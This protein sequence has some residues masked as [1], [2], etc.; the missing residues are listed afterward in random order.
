MP[1][2]NKPGVACVMDSLESIQYHKDTSYFF[3]LAAY[4]L[5]CDIF[6]ID[7][8]D[9]FLRYNRAWAV[10]SQLALTKQKHL[11]IEQRRELPLDE[12]RVILIRKDPPFDRR[13]FYTTLLLDLLPASTRV[14]NQ[15]SA[16]RDW[17]EKLAALHFADCTPP[18]LVSRDLKAI[19]LFMREQQQS[20]AAERFVLKPLDG[21]GG[22]GIKFVSGVEEL[23]TLVAATHNFSRYIVVQNYIDNSG[24]VRVIL[25]N[26]QVLGQ[27]IRKAPKGK[28]LNN[29]DQGGTAHPCDPTEQQTMVSRRVAEACQNRGVYFA[30]ID[31]LN[32][33]LIEINVTSPTGLQELARFQN[34]PLHHT[35][36]Q[37]FL[38]GQ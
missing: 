10:V 7:Q 15:P 2:Q 13:Y 6:H 21:R 38:S 26:G 17:N 25:L 29:L 12:L 11:K 9:I 19:Q 23:Q 8:G 5:G 3:L 36:M 37:S 33:Y 22:L 1:K 35:C 34:R 24:D 14:I 4:E 30:G 27:F 16:L 20:G 32:D 31:F 18:S 28:E